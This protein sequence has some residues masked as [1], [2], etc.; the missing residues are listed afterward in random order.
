MIINNHLSFTTMDTKAILNKKFLAQD[1]SEQQ[2]Y[3]EL[4]KRYKDIACNYATMENAIAVLS[5]MRTNASYIYYGN[6]SE[7]LGLCNDNEKNEVSSIWEEEIF[8]LI[9]PDDLA[10]KHLHEL[11]FYHFIK[12]QPKKKSAD[13]YLLSKI[14]IKAEGGYIPVWH[15]MFY[16]YTPS[17]RTLW[18]ALCLYSPLPFNL[19]SKCLIVNSVNGQVIEL[20]KQSNSQILSNREIQVLSLVDKGMTSKNIAHTL[21]ISINTVSRHR[22]EILGKL[23]VKNSIEACRVAKDLELI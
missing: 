10:Q 12:K 22:Q 18:L 20:E 6:F 5:D 16:I 2:H 15:R 7:T 19:S 3:S 17:N 21:S 4:L 13:F 14:R 11:C 8:K 9:H 1:F 23:Q